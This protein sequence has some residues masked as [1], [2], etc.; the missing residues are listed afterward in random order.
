M[1]QAVE[2]RLG[3][4]GACLAQDLIGLA[5]LPDLTL[6]GLHPIRHIV[7]HARAL[8]GIDLAPLNPFEQCLR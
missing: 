7:R 3:E 1:K 8:A 4:I 6:Q 5:K 2:L